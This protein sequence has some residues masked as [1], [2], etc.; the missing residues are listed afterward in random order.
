MPRYMVVSFQESMDAKSTKEAAAVTVQGGSA[1]P[2]VYRNR[3][4]SRSYRLP[5]FLY[6]MCPNKSAQNG[7]W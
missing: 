3:A 6:D 4:G 2:P 7:A 1:R 5:T